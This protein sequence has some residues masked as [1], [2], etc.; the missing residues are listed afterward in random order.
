MGSNL[1]CNQAVACTSGPASSSNEY[2]LLCKVVPCNHLWTQSFPASGHGKGGTGDSGDMRTYRP[3]QVCA[4][5]YAAP[6]FAVSCKL[7]T[8]LHYWHLQEAV[9]PHDAGEVIQL[10]LDP[11]RDCRTPEDSK[12]RPR[13]GRAILAGSKHH[14]SDT[15]KARGRI[16]R[17]P[18]TSPQICPCLSSPSPSAAA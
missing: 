13:P 1:N 3:A 14:K 15:G 7:Q 16:G 6:S 12:A 5:P 10:A 18:S 8:C 4:T 2:S 9:L 17:N 11:P